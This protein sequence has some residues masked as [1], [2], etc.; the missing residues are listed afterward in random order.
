MKKLTAAALA[1]TLAGTMTLP[2]VATEVDLDSQTFETSEAIYSAIYEATIVLNG[3]ELDVSA[4]PNADGIPMRLVAESD[5]GSAVWFQEMNESYFYFGN[6]V[7]T[8]SFGTGAVY[9]NGVELEDMAVELI[10]GVTYLPYTIINE[11]EGYSAELAFEENLVS[12][13]IETPNGT[14]I[15]QLSSTVSTAAGLSM[16]MVVG[17]EELGYYSI[18]LSSLE[19][20]YAMFPMMTTPDTIIVGQIAEDADL[21]DLEAQ[22]DAY[23][24]TQAD[25]FSWYLSYNLPRVE[26][27]RF[28]V[29]NGYVLC[30]IA[31][32]A[33]AGVE[34][35]QQAVDNMA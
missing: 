20:W 12:I 22:W 27:A 9:L 30:L 3:T 15:A 32:N 33:D 4:I 28:E 17:E 5:F 34:A 19:S 35:F 25:T 6:N 2:V 21:T 1:L 23:C 31:E 18:D 14:P 10:D 7:I 11:M 8:V 26:D 16:G 13:A 24:T 29:Y